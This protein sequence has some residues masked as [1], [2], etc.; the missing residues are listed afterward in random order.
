MTEKPLHEKK[1]EE[2]LDEVYEGC[3]KTSNT[4]DSKVSEQS[5]KIIK[6]HLKEWAIAVV[7]NCDRF[8]VDVA[9][10]GNGKLRCDVEGD[11]RCP[12][13]YFLIDRFE[14]TEEDLK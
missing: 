3:L 1:I 5:V 11:G 9:H 12:V 6:H 13:C 8:W 2:R 7:K 10:F 4:Y 14:L